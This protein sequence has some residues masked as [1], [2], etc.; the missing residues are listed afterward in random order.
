MEEPLTIIDLDAGRI[1]TG[2]ATIE[3]IGWKLFRLILDIASGRQKS[4][5]EHWGLH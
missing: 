4:W 1:A 2:K 5:G 3:E